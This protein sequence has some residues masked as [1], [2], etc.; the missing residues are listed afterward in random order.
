MGPSRSDLVRVR[1]DKNKPAAPEP[2]AEEADFYQLQGGPSAVELHY[3]TT[4]GV[5]SFRPIRTA[6]P[7]QS[8]F[9]FDNGQDPQMPKDLTGPPAVPR[10]RLGLAGYPD[11]VQSQTPEVSRPRMDSNTTADSTSTGAV[12]DDV[13]NEVVER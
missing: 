9:S 13:A 12:T 3:A 5:D 11:R 1:P 6:P 10:H 2:Q 7:M 4:R 8:V